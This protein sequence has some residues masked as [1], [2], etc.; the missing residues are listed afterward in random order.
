MDGLVIAGILIALMGAIGFLTMV[1]T[2]PAKQHA[3]FFVVAYSAMSF[4]GV[5]IMAVASGL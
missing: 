3:K 1:T 5:A 2:P 4:I